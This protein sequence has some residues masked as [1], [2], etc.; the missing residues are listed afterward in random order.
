MDCE[1]NYQFQGKGYSH[2]DYPM[3]GT[4]AH[5]R[6]YEDVYFCTKC[7]NYVKKNRVYKGNSYENPLDGSFPMGPDK[8]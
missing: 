6:Y 3:P 2:E 7:L 1:H 5:A 8:K 4:G